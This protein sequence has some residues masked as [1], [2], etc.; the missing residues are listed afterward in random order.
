MTTVIFHK[1]EKWELFKINHIILIIICDA[2]DAEDEELATPSAARLLLYSYVQRNFDYCSV[3]VSTVSSHSALWFSSLS[4]V[5]QQLKRFGI[6]V[7]LLN[8]I[9]NH[10]TKHYQ[11]MPLSLATFLGYTAKVKCPSTLSVLINE[12]TPEYYT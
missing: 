6:P 11:L 4:H 2:S 5:R 10:I 3:H 8:M 9:R 7:A 12:A 1:S